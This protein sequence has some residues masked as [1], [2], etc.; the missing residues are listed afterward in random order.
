MA[1]LYGNLLKL[2]TQ[3]NSIEKVSFLFFVQS[4]IIFETISESKKYW[5]NIFAAI[6]ETS[7]KRGKFSF[8]LVLC[9]MKLINISKHAEVQSSLLTFADKCLHEALKKYLV[10]DIQAGKTLLEKLNRSAEKYG[11]QTTRDLVRFA[12]SRILALGYC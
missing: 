9:A 6:G 11:S 8:G 10:N 7:E 4:E 12:S 5:R 1:S 3:K 2:T